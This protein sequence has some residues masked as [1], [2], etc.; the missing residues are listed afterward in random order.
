MDDNWPLGVSEFKIKMNQSDIEIVNLLLS[1]DQSHLFK[2]WQQMSDDNKSEFLKQVKSLHA[3][4]LPEQGGLGA[5]IRNSRIL[6]QHAKSGVNPMD[7]WSPV[8]PNGEVLSPSTEKYDNY[9]KIGVSEV[10]FCGFVL[11]AGTRN[12]ICFDI[13]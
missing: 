10:P 4:Y 1:L 9:H 11:V 7:G 3:S 2:D 12:I 6:L 5:Y 13:S 8:V